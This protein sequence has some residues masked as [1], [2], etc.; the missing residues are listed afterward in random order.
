MKTFTPLHLQRSDLHVLV[1]QPCSA[2]RLDLYI[3]G[4]DGQQGTADPVR[5]LIVIFASCTVALDRRKYGAKRKRPQGLESAKDVTRPSASVMCHECLTDMM[6]CCSGN[7]KVL[8]AEED[9]DVILRA[10]D[11]EE[12]L[13]A[14]RRAMRSKKS[15]AVELVSTLPPVPAAPK[16]K[17][18]H[19]RRRSSTACLTVPVAPKQKQAHKRL[20][21]STSEDED[22]DAILRDLDE[23]EQCQAARRVLRSKKVQDFIYDYLSFRLVT[24]EQIQS[25]FAE[26]QGAFSR[27]QLVEVCPAE[28]DCRFW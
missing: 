3:Q 11:E 13:Q 18:A 8:V 21:S 26:L 6:V 25:R 4:E 10:L 19:K 12:R 27:Q 20:R 14:A 7:R 22:I 24:Q 16:Q 5:L 2:G 15:M 9:I 28:C 1:S 17:Q 23:K